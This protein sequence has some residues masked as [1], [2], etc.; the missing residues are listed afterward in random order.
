MIDFFFFKELLHNIKTKQDWCCCQPR[1]G[2]AVRD[3]LGALRDH[4]NPSPALVENQCYL[5]AM[6]VGSL[7]AWRLGEVPTAES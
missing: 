4:A 3:T 1:K 2:L 7:S 5:Q 6:A